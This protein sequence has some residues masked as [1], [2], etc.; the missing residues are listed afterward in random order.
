M[1]QKLQTLAIFCLLLVVCALV[2]R[3]SY[4]LSTAPLY[5]QEIRIDLND[6]HFSDALP[7]ADSFAR[8]WGLRLSLADLHADWLWDELDNL[9][10]IKL[11]VE[12]EIFEP[13]VETRFFPLAGIALKKFIYGEQSYPQRIYVHPVQSVMQQRIRNAVHLSYDNVTHSLKLTLKDKNPALISSLASQVPALYQKRRELIRDENELAV[14]TH[15]KKRSGS[16]IRDSRL[17]RLAELYRQQQQ[18]DQVLTSPVKVLPPSVHSDE[19]SRVQEKII[20]GKLR[21]DQLQRDKGENDPSVITLN[22]LIGLEMT[23]FNRQLRPQMATVEK[24]RDMLEESIF[25]P[26]S[27]KKRG[28]DL[29]MLECLNS[30][31]HCDSNLPTIKGIIKSGTIEVSQLRSRQN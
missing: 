21:R 30:T 29:S 6:P 16:I 8:E 27:E 13:R 4:Q 1:P 7:F 25:N 24:I 14:F 2:A 5:T 19:L 22:Q 26:A 11:I 3:T 18:I 20:L 17:G 31:A 12:K 15:K 28:Q 9:D 23:E 10:E